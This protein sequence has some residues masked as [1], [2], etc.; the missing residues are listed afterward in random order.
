[1][2]LES[3]N[4]IDPSII[5]R[6]TGRPDDIYG[7]GLLYTW[8]A[9][10]NSKFAP[11]GWRVPTQAELTT[12]VNF[13]GGASVAG[14]PLKSTR[15][16]LTPGLD[17]PNTGATNASGFNWLGCGRRSNFGSFA[18]IGQFTF[19]WSINQVD[20]GNARVYYADYLSSNLNNLSLSKAYGCSVRCILDNPN[21][22]KPGDTVTDVDGNIYPTVK[23]GT[24]VWMASNYKCKRLNDGTPIPNVTNNAAWAALTS[25]SALGGAA[26]CSYNNAA[27]VEYSKDR[28]GSYDDYNI[29]YNKDGTATFNGTN[30]YLKLKALLNL[31]TKYSIEIR[32]KLDSIP[33]NPAILVAK[34]AG[35]EV[36]Y[37]GAN[38]T[39]YHITSGASSYIAWTRDTNWHTLI[40]SRNGNSGA[41]YLDGVSLTINVAFNS[42]GILSIGSIGAQPIPTTYFPGQIDYINIWNRALSASEVANIS[43]NKTFRA[44]PYTSSTLFHIN[45][46][47][48]IIQDRTNKITPVATNVLIKPYGKTKMMEFNG[49]S[50]NVNLG[51]NSLSGNLTIMG[52]LNLYSY[53]ES[54]VGT[55]LSNGQTHVEVNS[56]GALRI[57][58]DNSTYAA[59]ANGIVSKFHN[60]VFFAITSTNT[61]VSNIYISDIKS[62]PALSGTANQSAGTPVAGSTTYL[63][64]KSSDAATTKG[65]S[66]DIR[67]DES[68]LTLAEITQF[69]SATR[70]KYI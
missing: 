48:G 17:A 1:M 13:L 3:K 11:T 38:N 16:G 32:F 64:N 68:I 44:L 69:Y 46:D 50:G 26:W 62:S 10:S 59:S 15:T 28:I 65:L 52:W 42:T 29:V 43:S 70:N 12:L 57:T 14:G 54:N 36:I 51:S 67:L 66:N 8:W 47:R 24:Q 27:I 56:S 19:A 63:G 49:T 18:T 41:I 23:I 53:G 30:A 6:W 45:C 39:I 5:F 7:Y 34:S 61:G 20:V 60:L 35:S 4:S 37:I 58:R 9:A 31:G 22:W 25:S 33:S 55:I 40:I 2:A 21:N